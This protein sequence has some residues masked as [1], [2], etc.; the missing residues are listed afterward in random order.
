MKLKRVALLM[1][2][3]GLVSCPVFAADNTEYNRHNM[4]HHHDQDSNREVSYKG[5][6]FPRL[7]TCPRVNRYLPILDAMSQN[8]GRAQ[9]T[10]D[11]DKPIQFAGGINFDY[12]IGDLTDGYMGENSSRFSVNDAYLNATGH[13]NDW[14]HAFLEVSYTNLSDVGLDDSLLGP[15]PTAF[16]D[17][18]PGL[19]SFGYNLGEL[20]LQQGYITIGDVTRFP[21]FLRLGKQFL[22]YGRYVIHPPTR[23]VTQVMTE[24]LQTAAELSFI[25]GWSGMDLHGS[26]FVFQDTMG[27]DN[28]DDDQEDDEEF[29]PGHKHTNYGA[30]L[31]FGKVSNQLGWDVGVGWMYNILGVNDM[32]YA[33][34]LFRNGSDDGVDPGEGSYEKRV[35]GLTAYG[36]INSGPFSLAAH[37]ATAL[38]HFDESD[39]TSED[40]DD[41]DDDVEGAKPWAFDITAAYNFVYWG[42]SQN[43]YVGFQ[44]TGD[45]ANLFLPEDRVVA[46]YSIDVLKNT[47]VGLEYTW[48]H[49]YGDDEG[50]TGENSNRVLVRVAVKFG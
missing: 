47:N 16:H 41:G 40:D 44:T 34:T 6:D 43:L 5:E 27:S 1:S 35:S 9:P 29:D 12:V 14:V 17:P 22:D 13:V 25:T 38:R 18:K 48:D 10:V 4:K 46:G 26:F 2:V 3:L 11:C 24:T 15:G 49:D 30:Q 20:T 19:Y 50:G 45:A 23:S 7:T 36:T 31:G 8:V 32:A 42:K 37:Y 39:L 21:L 28:D 33:V